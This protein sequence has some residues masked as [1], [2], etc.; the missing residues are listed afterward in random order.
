M[1]ERL[2][3]V[4]LQANSHVATPPSSAALPIKQ[5]S[6]SR[7]KE[8]NRRRTARHLG[9]VKSKTFTRNKNNKN[10]NNNY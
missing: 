1:L 2:Q 7:Q 10:N 9:W 6:E 8:L 5:I 4:K 3:A